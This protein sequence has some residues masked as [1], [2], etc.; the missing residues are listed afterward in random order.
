MVYGRIV[1][2]VTNMPAGSTDWRETIALLTDIWVDDYCRIAPRADLVETETGDFSYLFDLA[3]ERLVAAWGQSR[4]RS[5][6]L[7]DKGRMA[8]HPLSAGDLYHRGHAIPHT[9]GGG[10]DINLVAQLGRIN[11]GPFRPLEKQ[12]VATPGSLYFTYWTYLGSGPHGQT[13]TGVDQGLLIA[14]EPPDIRHH[15]N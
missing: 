13:P 6:E 1:E 12:A 4:G 8:G 2:V 14:G 3:A 11:I 15:G 7:R 10:T 5:D 9:L